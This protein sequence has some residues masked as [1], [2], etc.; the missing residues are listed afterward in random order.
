MKPVVRKIEHSGYLLLFKAFSRPIYAHLW[1][2]W[3]LIVF[4]L[5]GASDYQEAPINN[6]IRG[7]PLWMGTLGLLFEL[8]VIVFHLGR[9]DD[10]EALLAP[11]ADRVFGRL[12]LMLWF[13]ALLGAIAV[14][15]VWV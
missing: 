7:K 9:K 3:L 14:V 10:R 11:T 8:G 13:M 1:I 15:V 2:C 6:A 12:P 4:M 5:I